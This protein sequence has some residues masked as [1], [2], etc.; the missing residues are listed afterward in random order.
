MELTADRLENYKGV[1]TSFPYPAAK[2][3]RARHRSP[4]RVGSSAVSGL[5]SNAGAG[6]LPR[7]SDRL[8]VFNAFL[9]DT[10]AIAF[11]LLLCGI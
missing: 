10:T 11:I 4:A 6:T 3:A 5:G 2:R 9:A 8:T 7:R 1:L